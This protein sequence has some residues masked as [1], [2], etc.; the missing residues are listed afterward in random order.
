MWRIILII[1]LVLGSYS[2]AEKLC[3][4]NKL[5]CSDGQ[6]CCFVE[7]NYKC[8]PAK[9][10][11]G[12]LLTHS[13]DTTVPTN[14]SNSLASVYYSSSCLT[15]SDCTRMEK[16]CPGG[17]LDS[18]YFL[19]S[20]SKYSMSA[21]QNST[22]SSEDPLDNASMD[23][24]SQIPS[25]V[26][27][28]TKSTYDEDNKYSTSS[29]NDESTTSESWSPTLSQ[30]SPQSSVSSSDSAKESS[31]SDTSKET[32]YTSIIYNEFLKSL[33]NVSSDQRSPD[34]SVTVRFKTGKKSIYTESNSSSDTSYVCESSTE[35][36]PNYSSLEYTTTVNSNGYGHSTEKSTK[37][38]P[39]WEDIPPVQHFSQSSNSEVEFDITN[40]LPSAVVAL[41]PNLKANSYHSDTTSIQNYIQSN[42]K[43][44]E[45]EE[46]VTASAIAEDRSQNGRK[47][48]HTRNKRLSSSENFSPESAASNFSLNHPLIFSSEEE[49]TIDETYEEGMFVPNQSM[50]TPSEHRSFQVSP[51]NNGREIDE[52][53][54]SLSQFS[55]ELSCKVYYPDE[56]FIKR[57]IDG[58]ENSPLQIPS[59]RSC[60]VSSLNE[61][62]IKREI[63]KNKN[64]SLQTP[65]DRSFQIYPLQTIQ[66]MESE[67]GEK[68]PSFLLM[69]SDRSFE[70][71]SLNEELNEKEIGEDENSLLDETYEEGMFV[72]NQSLLT[73]S[74]HRS[75]QVSPLNN[76]REIDENGDQS[77]Q[78]SSTTTKYMVRG[79]EKRKG[80]ETNGKISKEEGSR[81]NSMRINRTCVSRS[82]KLKP[83]RSRGLVPAFDKTEYDGILVRSFNTK[84]P[85]LSEREGTKKDED[86]CGNSILSKR[87]TSSFLKSK[88]RSVTSSI[89]RVHDS[90]S[91]T[92]GLEIMGSSR[93]TYSR[94]GS[95]SRNPCVSFIEHDIIEEMPTDEEDIF[96]RN[97]SPSCG[98]RQNDSPIPHAS[99]TKNRD[100]AME[101]QDCVPSPIEEDSSSSEVEFLR[102]QTI[103]AQRSK[104][105]RMFSESD[106]SVVEDFSRTPP[107]NL[108]PE[109][110][111]EQLFRPCSWSPSVLSWSSPAGSWYGDEPF[112]E[113]FSR[114]STPSPS[115]DLQLPED[116]QN[117][118]WSTEEEQTHVDYSNVQSSKNAFAPGQGLSLSDDERPLVMSAH[119]QARTSHSSAASRDLQLPEDG[120]NSPWSFEEEQSQVDYSNALS[121]KSVLAPDQHLS[122]SDDQMPLGITA[123]SHARTS[124]SSAE[125]PTDSES[126]LELS[127]PARRRR[128]IWDRRSIES[129][130]PHSCS[131]E[132]NRRLNSVASTTEQL[133][134]MESINNE[135]TQDF[136][137]DENIQIPVIEERPSSAQLDSIS[138]N[139]SSLNSNFPQSSLDSL[140]MQQEQYSQ[141]SS[142]EESFET[143]NTFTAPSSNNEKRKDFT[144]S[145]LIENDQ[146]NTNKEYISPSDIWYSDKNIPKTTQN[147]N[148]KLTIDQQN[149]QVTPHK[150]SMLSLNIKSQNLSNKNSGIHCN[151]V[152]NEV[153]S[154]THQQKHSQTAS[155]SSSSETDLPR[156]N[157]QKK[158]IR[159]GLSA[160]QKVSSIFKS[161]REKLTSLI[162]RKQSVSKITVHE[163]V[164]AMIHQHSIFSSYN[165]RTA[166]IV[167]RQQLE[168]S[169]TNQSRGTR[170]RK[171]SV[172]RQRSESTTS[173]QQSEPQATCQRLETI[174]N[175]LAETTATHQ[176]LAPTSTR[177]SSATTASCERSASTAIRQR[178]ASTASR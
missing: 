54:H 67:I 49:K 91:S 118:P 124:Y 17:L 117:S 11:E 12:Q 70:V 152:V 89:R 31:L 109:R 154:T 28:E 173:R 106:I 163:T 105:F 25:V 147:Q 20:E 63:D 4:D 98:I 145:T 48:E 76:E 66:Y 59:E 88:P 107:H 33:G 68:E 141:S 18:S 128:S 52:N 81:D 53:E 144:L 97:S 100:I 58:D 26:S 72:P 3:P 34:E 22:G 138:V 79:F 38:C 69:S 10:E 176:Q 121:S 35:G 13:N 170:Q 132:I 9:P 45:S 155:D 92:C 74:E 83:R 29:M 64:S 137:V 159:S 99:L 160:K 175:Q 30:S 6:S 165:R 51:L 37:A 113:H 167:M 1:E 101:V 161:R 84:E 60:Q 143:L 149:S 80:F 171:N 86:S 103:P 148:Y 15:N 73:P 164:S 134:P 104:R 129:S 119:S 75:F 135:S 71:P 114:L 136:D 172:L 24:K 116:G 5:S 21:D 14:Y 32:S 50:L 47:P 2:F 112:P 123:R 157:H 151:S 62:F 23:I 7:G 85:I 126:M 43:E 177:Q 174:A 139:A 27:T 90:F 41:S 162:T 156:V 87:P 93:D 169:S 39:D 131:P 96:R 140:Q 19:M 56:E 95:R 150:Q 94:E 178:S 110:T 55:S 16:C 130:S 57:E 46:T 111:P 166:S 125:Y 78:E 108:P 142:E 44:I 61:I 82:E 158:L 122:L 65:S 153:S 102:N 120:Q 168:T 8:C 77:C 115:R 42:K 146:E 127:R 40:P 36:E 133:S